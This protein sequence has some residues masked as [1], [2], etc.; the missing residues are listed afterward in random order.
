M[1]NKLFSNQITCYTWDIKFHYIFG[2]SKFNHF[3]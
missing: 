1:F 2:S 3:N